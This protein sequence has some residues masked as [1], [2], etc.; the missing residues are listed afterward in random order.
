MKH[1][2]I[3]F[4]IYTVLYEAII[5]GIF[6]YGVFGLGHS[7]WWMLLACLL[8]ASQLKLRHFGIKQENGIDDDA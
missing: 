4:T 5:W 3:C 7:G 2:L 1:N 6:G 8:S